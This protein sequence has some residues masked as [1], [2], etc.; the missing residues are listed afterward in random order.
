MSNIVGSRSYQSPFCLMKIPVLLRLAW[1]AQRSVA[2]KVCQIAPQMYHC[3]NPVCVT[4][5][6]N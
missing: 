2:R 5:R 1:V 4:L 3:K 6:V